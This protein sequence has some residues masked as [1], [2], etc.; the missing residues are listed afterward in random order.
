MTSTTTIRRKT[1]KVAVGVEFIG[2]DA[3]IVVQSMATSATTNIDGCVDDALSIANAGGKIVRYTAASVA[4]AKALGQIKSKL[5]DMGCNIPIVA[6]VHF[7]PQAAFTAAEIVEKVR[8]NPGNFVDARAKF[9]TIEY[10]D[11]EYQAEIEHLE[12]EFRKLLSICKNHGTALRIGVNHG[13]LSDRIMS[14]YGDTVGGMCE[15]AMEF[16]RVCKKDNFNNVVVSM[17]S[18]N[19]AV[20]VEAYRE[21]VT[22]MKFESMS[23]PLHLGV[24]EAGEGEDGR[25][26]SAIGIGTLLNE[27]IGDTIRVSLT[28]APAEEIKVADAIVAH[29]SQ[30]K[31][32]NITPLTK[33]RTRVPEVIYKTDK[34]CSITPDKP[35][36][37]RESM[38]LKTSELEQNAQF[39][40]TNPE[41]TIIFEGH[42]IDFSYE[43]RE[44]FQKITTL[45][46][47]NRVVLKREYNET[48]LNKL[49]VKASI[50]FG[51]SLLSGFC[52]GIAITNTGDKISDEQIVS[53]SYALL[54]SS[55]ARIT[56]TEFISCPGC[57]R[58]QF[59]L[60]ECVKRVKE[61]CSEFKG[62]KIAIMG[63]NVNGPGEMADADF[64]YVGAGKGKVNLYRK[65]EIIEKGVDET[66]A[67]EKLVELIKKG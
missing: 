44:L 53:L 15:S 58:T 67:I 52:D 39:L 10:T 47:Q 12:T 30:L 65:R 51:W 25:V 14:R 27:G 24:T 2:G 31:I 48:Y 28:E 4:E 22:R 61:S 38:V 17:K 34:P 57:G 9:E 16:L 29:I 45:N 21:I 35:E 37:E 54:Q 5:R 18:S 7:N 42:G 66:V 63:C 32:C 8:I 50:D 46:L 33:V 11:T 20:M 23:Y 56:R 59:S 19:V 3:P 55:R 13:S 6:D 49:I 36:I 43:C 26:K 64:G 1:T 60:Q 40:L 41:T 62:L